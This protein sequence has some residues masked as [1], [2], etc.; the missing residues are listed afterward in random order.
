MVSSP[1][2][3]FC[4]CF[5]MHF[6]A[7]VI[8]RAWTWHVFF[9]DTPFPCNL[10]CFVWVAKDYLHTKARCSDRGTRTCQL[11]D[12]SVLSTR[13]HCPAGQT[14]NNQDNVCT[15]LNRN[16]T[17]VIWHCLHSLSH[18]ADR[19]GTCDGQGR[20][21]GESAFR[22]VIS[23]SGSPRFKWLKFAVLA[24]LACLFSSVTAHS[25]QIIV[26]FMPCQTLSLF[27]LCK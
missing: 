24:G 1:A 11:T 8:L 18:H 27:R 26:E 20:K 22:I 19:S 16:D 5:G 12:L 15:D 14:T 2:Q 9:G 3:P 7:S 23:R 21:R 4:L 25:P 10:M 17:G 13:K 6:K